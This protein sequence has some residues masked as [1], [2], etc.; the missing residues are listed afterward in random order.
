LFH[1][2]T[3]GSLDVRALVEE[4]GASLDIRDDKGR[5]VTDWAKRFASLPKYQNM[6]DIKEIVKYLEERCKVSSSA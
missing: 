2:V 3:K 1:A 6:G 4:G 5:T